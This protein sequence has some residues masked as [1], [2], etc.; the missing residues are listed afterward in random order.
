MGHLGL[1]PQSVHVMGGFRVQAKQTETA[2]ALLADAKR[3]RL[4]VASQSCSRA[5]PT[6]SRRWSLRGSPSRRSGSGRGDRATARCWS[7]TTCS[8]WAPGSRGN[9]SVA[10]PTC[11][12]RSSRRSPPGPGT[13]EAVPSRQRGDV[14]HARG[15]SAPIEGL[16]AARLMWLGPVPAGVS[17]GAGEG[18]M[19]CPERG[20]RLE[21]GPEGGAADAAVREFDHLR[22]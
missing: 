6:S 4:R 19:P 13:S 16:V 18:D 8:G 5:C 20:P 2:N 21:P 9:S 17:P 3:S 10:T 15:P 22:R 1:T 14:P 7:P 11:A 12:L